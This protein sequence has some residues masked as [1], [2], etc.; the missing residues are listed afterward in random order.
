MK[1]YT[2]E[3][4]QTAITGAIRSMAQ[5]RDEIAAGN[6]AIAHYH[7]LRAAESLLV[8]ERWRFATVGTDNPATTAEIAQI[9]SAAIE[10]AQES[11]KEYEYNPESAQTVADLRAELKSGSDNAAQLVNDLISDNPNQATAWVTRDDIDRHAD[12]MTD[13]QRAALMDYMRTEYDLIDTS[14]EITN[15]RESMDELDK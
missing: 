6:Y 5:M 7:A 14:A 12:D 10:R 3:Q 4:I 8:A 13:E 9:H 15:A 1:N 11:A 2:T